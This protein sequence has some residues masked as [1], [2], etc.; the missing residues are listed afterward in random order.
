[1]YVQVLEIYDVVLYRI[2]MKVIIDYKDK[3][4]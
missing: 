1:M 4:L 3:H 2:D